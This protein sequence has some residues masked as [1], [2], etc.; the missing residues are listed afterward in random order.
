M[1]REKK[2]K[3]LVTNGIRVPQAIKRLHGSCIDVAMGKL[4]VALTGR[5]TRK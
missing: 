5:R 2:D 4:I 1:P 3:S